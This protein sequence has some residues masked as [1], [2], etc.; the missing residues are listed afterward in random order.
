MIEICNHISST[1]NARLIHSY[2]DVGP[3]FMGH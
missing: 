3:M 2:L 1:I